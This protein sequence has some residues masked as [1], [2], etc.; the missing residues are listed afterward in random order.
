MR[1][2]IRNGDC[3]WSLVFDYSAASKLRVWYVS[4]DLRYWLHNAQWCDSNKAR[5]FF[6]GK[7]IF[8]LIFFNFPK[9]NSY[10]KSAEFRN[11]LFILENYKRLSCRESSSWKN[12]PWFIRI[13][14][15]FYIRYEA[16]RKKVR[17]DIK[18][19]KYFIFLCSNFL[20]EINLFSFNW[21]L[22]YCYFWK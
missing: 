6:P 7:R 10:K 12:N 2:V 4:P 22:Q 14:S 17:V 18:F 19:I 16:I 15:F 5:I 8:N 3:N 11:N 13:A 21:S 20:L 1:Q 9:Q